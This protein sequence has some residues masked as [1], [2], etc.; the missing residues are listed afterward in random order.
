MPRAAEYHVFNRAS[1]GKPVVVG[2][3]DAPKLMVGPSHAVRAI[4]NKRMSRAAAKVFAWVGFC[5]VPGPGVAKNVPLP[6][7]W[8]W[9]CPC[10]SRL[11]TH[12]TLALPGRGFDGG[13]GSLELHCQLQRGIMSHIFGA[14]VERL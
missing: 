10:R 4:A 6:L 1:P 12:I 9:Y 14:I 2:V 11:T 8:L 5:M 13:H 7:S 3:L